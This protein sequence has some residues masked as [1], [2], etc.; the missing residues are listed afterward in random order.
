MDG[1][2]AAVLVADVI[3]L[4]TISTIVAKASGS[5]A[6][7]LGMPERDYRDR[8]ELH[9]GLRAGSDSRWLTR[10]GRGDR[11]SEP[12]VPAL[13]R[14]TLAH[15]ALVGPRTMSMWPRHDPV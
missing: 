4:R 15:P 10:H 3:R 7:R 1:A 5:Q 13:R 12:T 9:E 8:D 2:G 14:P 6:Q 11:P